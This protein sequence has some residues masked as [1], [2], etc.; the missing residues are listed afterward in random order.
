MCRCSR[1]AKK[2]GNERLN[3]ACKRAIKYQTYTYRSIRN[4]LEKQL[5]KLEEQIEI[6]YKTPSHDNIRGGNYYATNYLYTIIPSIYA[7]IIQFIYSL[8]IK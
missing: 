6:D 1:L 8:N 3:N 5:D 7:I 4:I 2:L